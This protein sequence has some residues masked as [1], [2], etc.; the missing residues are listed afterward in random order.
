VTLTNLQTYERPARVEDAWDLLS[1]GGKHAK[2]VGGGV[3]L[4]LF[5]PPDVTTLIDVSRLGDR[6][7]RFTEGGLVIGASVTLTSL[8]E[9]AEAEAYM[10]GILVTVLRQVASPLL[11]NVATVAGSIAGTHPWSDV[12]TLFL[13]LNAQVTRYAG[14]SETVALEE[15]LRAR[16]TIDRAVITEVT[17]PTMPD[18]TFVSYEKFVR[19]GFDIGMLNCAYLLTAADHGCEGVRVVFGGTP[20]MAHR[21]EALESALDGASLTDETIDSVA[22]LASEAVPVRDDVRA[23][24]WYRA[25]L[26]GAG[27]RRCVTRIARKV[28]EQA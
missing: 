6:S 4:A 15:L 26:A 5:V 24:A 2:L 1:S 12:I 23:S 28:S 18:R 20:E 13:A 14:Q 3:D 22:T 9:S 27:T 11:R 7:V 8:L 21:V 25:V 19:T 16:G 17:L 10:D